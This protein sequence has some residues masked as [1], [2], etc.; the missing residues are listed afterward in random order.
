MA[1]A[2][3]AIFSIASVGLA[4]VIYTE[5]KRRDRLLQDQFYK[6]LLVLMAT[7]PE[8]VEEKMKERLKAAEEAYHGHFHFDFFKRF[9]HE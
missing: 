9:H 4:C 8:L 3:M 7:A 6:L 2:V 1:T 5:S